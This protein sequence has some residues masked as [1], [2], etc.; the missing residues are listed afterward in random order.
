[1][2]S[3]AYNGKIKRFREVKSV[4]K[5]I[6]GMFIDESGGENNGSGLSAFLRRNNGV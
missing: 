6:L 3:T 2:I 1:V 4:E 5:E